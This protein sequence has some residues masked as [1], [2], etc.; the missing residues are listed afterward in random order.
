[1]EAQCKH[2]NEFLPAGRHMGTSGVRRHLATCQIR[3]D[4]HLIVK[5][6]KSSVSSPNTSVLKK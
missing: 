1:M 2:C 5:K 6:L 3:S 4:L